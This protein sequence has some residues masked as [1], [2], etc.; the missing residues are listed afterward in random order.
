MFQSLPVVFL[1]YFKNKYRVG[2]HFLH[3][4]AC[5]QN[6][7]CYYKDRCD[8]ILPS[9]CG[10]KLHMTGTTILAVPLS[11]PQSYFEK[12]SN[13]SFH[14]QCACFE[15]GRHSLSSLVVHATKSAVI[16]YFVL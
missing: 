2:V 7:H 15:G 14:T 16:L 9:P 8:V 1:Y 10:Y 11:E 4:N 3:N 12:T 5:L 6:I 13:K